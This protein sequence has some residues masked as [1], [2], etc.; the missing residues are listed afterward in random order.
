MVLIV[1]MSFSVTRSCFKYNQKIG[2]K[3]CIVE[4][5]WCRSLACLAAIHL[6]D[7]IG[8]IGPSESASQCI[9]K[10]A[11]KSKRCQTFGGSSYA[12]NHDE[13]TYSN[14]QN[15]EP[16]QQIDPIIESAES[17]THIQI[18][19]RI[20][21]SEQST[22]STSSIASIQIY[23]SFDPFQRL[24]SPFARKIRFKST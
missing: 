19:N 17:N 20:E 21:Q 12:N 8:L 2:L 9:V 14:I 11:K 7:L 1:Y 18:T 15:V 4:A 22:Q 3:D 23:N 13:V 5:P 16:A 24:N 10:P 6:E